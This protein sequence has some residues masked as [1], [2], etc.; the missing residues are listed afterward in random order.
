MR[1]MDLRAMPG[2]LVPM[3]LAGSLSVSGALSKPAC[4]AEQN[5]AGMVIRFSTEIE[6]ERTW[7]LG[8]SQESISG[9][10]A[11]RLSGLPVVT[12]TFGSDGEYVCKIGNV[13]TDAADCPAKDGSYW[14]YWRMTADG[15]RHSGIGASAARVRCGSVEGW[16][17]LQGGSGPAPS[18]GRF[19]SIC[20]SAACRASYSAISPPPSS[21]ADAPGEETGSTPAPGLTGPGSSGG[22][23]QAPSVPAGA[24][25]VPEKAASRSD[26]LPGSGLPPPADDL[27]P[28]A[29]E[30][31]Q[32]STIGWRT[33]MGKPSP[34]PEPGREPGRELASDERKTPPGLAWG[35]STVIALLGTFRGYLF[36]RKQRA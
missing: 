13:G 10:E 25:T 30:A 12:R 7:C 19:A 1:R 15:W 16:A 6:N 5:R 27:R 3:L 20:P 34:A 32:P 24:E 35:L 31:D 8:F 17:W 23:E 33:A 26:N 4:A 2:L 14:G 18:P 28:G 29:G 9:I 22:P 11:L 21:G 36:W